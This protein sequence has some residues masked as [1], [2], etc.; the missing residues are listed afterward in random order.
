MAPRDSVRRFVPLRTGTSSP[1]EDEEGR[2]TLQGIVFDVD[3]TLYVYSPALTCLV[4]NQIWK[5]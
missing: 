4:F 3:G 2:L 5:T 1:G